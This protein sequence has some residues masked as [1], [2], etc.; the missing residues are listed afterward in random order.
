MS[1]AD[2][3]EI[4]H[5]E[6]ESLLC[7]AFEHPKDRIP[8]EPIYFLHSYIFKHVKPNVVSFLTEKNKLNL[9]YYRHT[10]EFVSQDFHL[11]LRSISK[12]NIN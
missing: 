11:A 2:V 10:I 1:S 5:L 9:D 3:C 12:I 7:C 6:N 8:N 4:T